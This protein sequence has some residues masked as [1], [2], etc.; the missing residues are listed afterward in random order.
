M[1]G[2]VTQVYMKTMHHIVHL[3]H[4]NIIEPP[5][6]ELEK[7]RRRKEQ[8]MMMTNQEVMNEVTADTTEGQVKTEL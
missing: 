7:I 6:E 3:Q 2:L 1:I 5:V 8:Q 4:N